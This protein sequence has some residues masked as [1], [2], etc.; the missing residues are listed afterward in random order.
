MKKIPFILA[1]FR[2]K[3]ID[4]AGAEK[5]VIGFMWIRKGRTLTISGVDET[6]RF[7]MEM[8]HWS[9]IKGNV[10]MA[11]K[12]KEISVEDLKKLQIKDQNNEKENSMH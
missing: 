11:K 1:L 10:R 12:P 9:I 8:S 2:D 6:K 5:V 3:T 7:M 4:V